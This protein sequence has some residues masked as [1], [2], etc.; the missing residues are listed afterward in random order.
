MKQRLE[1]IKEL[2]HELYNVLC[3]RYTLM[4]DIVQ[5]K[6]QDNNINTFN[7][8][9]DLCHPKVVLLDTT[10]DDEC[11]DWVLNIFSRYSKRSTE[12]LRT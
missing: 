2:D 11:N 7:I 9:E 8:V 10:N 5:F 1:R 3:E 4:K 6:R 12:C